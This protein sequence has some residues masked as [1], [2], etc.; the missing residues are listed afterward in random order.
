MNI[1]DIVPPEEWPVME[2][3]V[4][5]VRNGEIPDPPKVRRITKSGKS[6][7]AIV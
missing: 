2:N 4:K 6:W 3:V 5:R 7:D 1:H